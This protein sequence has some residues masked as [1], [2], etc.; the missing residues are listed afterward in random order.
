MIKYLTS[1]L[2]SVQGFDTQYLFDTFQLLKR[3]V[4]FASLNARVIVG[5]KP[6]ACRNFRLGEPSLLTNPFELLAQFLA[7]VF[8]VFGSHMCINI[9]PFERDRHV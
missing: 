4:F 1:R 3:R 6:G 8:L 9:P 2:Q 5:T 7:P